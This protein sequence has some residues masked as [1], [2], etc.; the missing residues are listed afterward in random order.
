MGSKN[1]IYLQSWTKLVETKAI[2]ARISRFPC[3]E[4]PTR[5]HTEMLSLPP[6]LIQCCLEGMWFHQ[7]NFGGKAT[8]VSG[9]NAPK[10][11]RP[12]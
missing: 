8:L 5:L 11:K 1:Y 10:T 12:R 4:T 7:G 3:M 9:Q 6:S 2:S